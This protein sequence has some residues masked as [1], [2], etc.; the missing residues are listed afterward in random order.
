M[1]RSMTGQGQARA[2]GPLGTMSVEVR[3]VNNRHLKLTT[4]LGD[5]LMRLEPR[6]ERS[7]RQH[8]QRG[9]VQLHAIWHRTDVA[10]PYEVN[11]SMLSAYYRQISQLRSELGVT[12][13]IDLSQLVSLPGVV[14]ESEVEGADAEVIW[15][16]F[17]PVLEA[18]LQNL[19]LMRRREGDAME[20]QLL[21]DLRAL[22]QHAGEVRQLAP[23]VL[24]G[25]RQRL[26][27][28]LQTALREYDAEVEPAIV[29]RELQ[30][31]ADRCDISEELTRLDS[32]CEMFRR[33]IAQEAAAGR[34]LDFVTQELFRETNTIGSKA[35]DA[36]IS[37]HVVEMKC[38]IERMRELVQNV[39]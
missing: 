26:K 6:I 31:Y 22:Q 15:Q 14:E 19:D 30:L 32:H 8:V 35:S 34:K 33:S 37:G 2:E 12:P 7:V 18:A 20:E 3:S 10:A 27:S 13:P 9:T 36:M 11:R 28:R 16:V 25:Y 39:E 21:Q 5:H 1:L 29:V 38:A 24:D 4:R 23:S 17:Q